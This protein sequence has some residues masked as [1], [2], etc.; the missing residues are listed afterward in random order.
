[1]LYLLQDYQEIGLGQTLLRA[2]LAALQRH[3]MTH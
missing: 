3:G 1:M 2:L